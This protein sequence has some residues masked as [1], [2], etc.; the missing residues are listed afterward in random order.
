MSMSLD[1]MI[2]KSS[3]SRGPGPRRI[4]AGGRGGGPKSSGAA[5]GS[6]SGSDVRARVLSVGAGR[7]GGT[8]KRSGAPKR[9]SGGSAGSFL[10]R[11]IEADLEEV[12][13]TPF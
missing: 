5:G 11:D 8:T 6:K 10:R 7:G 13:L 4:G 9:T 1:A 3:K 12:R 2:E